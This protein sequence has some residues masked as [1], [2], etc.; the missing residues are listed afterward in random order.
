M[1]QGLLQL[2][3]T[4]EVQGAEECNAIDD[5]CNGA[6]D[7]GCGYSTGGVQI[8]ISWNSGADIDLYVSDPSGEKVFYNEEDRHTAAGG[9]LD[10]D[11][12][13]ACREE[14]QLNTIENAYWPTPAPKGHYAIELHYFGPCGDSVPTVVTMGV[15]LN[16]KAAGHFQYTLAPEERLTALEFNVE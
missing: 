13:G 2:G 4:C 9:V 3:G 15:A 16:G 7:E 5:N 6:I 1:S 12:R 10:Y 14:Q 8:T 11:S